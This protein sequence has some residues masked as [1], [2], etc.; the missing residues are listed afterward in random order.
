MNNGWGPQRIL[1]EGKQ[2]TGV[3]FKRCMSVF[4]ETGRFNPEYDESQIMRIEADT[5]LVTIGQGTDVEFLETSPELA[6]LNLTPRGTL[7]INGET[8]QTNIPNIFASGEITTGPNIAVQAI[9]GGR[10]AAN[11]INRY[12]RL[13]EEERH[14]L[15]EP[16]PHL[17]LTALDLVDR[18][19][20]EKVPKSRREVMPRLRV[21]IMTTKRTQ[22]V[23]V[24]TVMPGGRPLP[25]PPWSQ[26]VL[27]PLQRPLKIQR[28]VLYQWR[29]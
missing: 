28:S 22:I 14:V 16:L 23:P 25:F 26:G 8:M 4:D 13:G 27:P 2:V 9:A 10:K 1:G 24:H 3:E 7:V 6:K 20:L 17:R 15:V 11:T 29:R 18:R 12:L 19:E 21:D 5:V